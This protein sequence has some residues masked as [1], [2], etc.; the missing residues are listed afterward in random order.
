MHRSGAIHPKKMVPPP[1]SREEVRLQTSTAYSAPA[2]Q[3]VRVNGVQNHGNLCRPA[4]GT[5]FGA[6]PERD[7][8]HE[9]SGFPEQFRVNR[10]GTVI[11]PRRVTASRNVER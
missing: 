11:P 9:G 2:W 8:P 7:F 4:S 5:G 1:S 6:N 3:Q 10:F